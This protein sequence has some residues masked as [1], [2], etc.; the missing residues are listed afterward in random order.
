VF[1]DFGQDQNC[2]ANKPLAY[3]EHSARGSSRN[4]TGQGTYE[5][6]WTP[7]ATDVGNVTIYVAGNAANGDSTNLGDRI[8]TRSYPLTPGTG[9]PGGTP[10]AI[11]AGGVITAGNFGAFPSI[12]P[13]TWVEIYGTNLS[14]AT[15]EW[16]GSDFTGNT[17]PT[18]LD[19]VKVTIGGQSAFVRFIT[20][21]QVNVQVPSNVPTGQQQLTISNAGGT[22]AA[23]NVTVNALQPGLNA[24]PSF[25]IGDRQYVVAQHSDLTFVL[26]PGSI[27]GLTTRQAQPGETIVIYGVGFGPA[28]DSSNAAIPA[29]TI[30]T[31]LNQLTNPIEMRVNN[32]PAALGYAGLAPNF[33]GLYQFNLVVP[34]I[35]DNDAAPLTF[36]LN[37][38]PGSQTLFLAVKQ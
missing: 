16:A 9:T 5:F 28:N 36:T 33:V 17:A 15:R 1:R 12:A 31:A 38:A 37:G 24:P 7:P 6:D 26:P 11:S 4:L 35:P 14:P 23:Y 34:T 22:S 3:I 21:A 29:G 8:Y 2:P 18:S 13:G 30:V 19:N 25:K 27:P 10:P 32:Q 20:P